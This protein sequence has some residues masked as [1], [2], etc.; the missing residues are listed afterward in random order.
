[1]RP[2]CVC[3]CVCVCVYIYI[4]KNLRG[5]PDIRIRIVDTQ[6][7]TVA[8]L[9]GRLPLSIIISSVTPRTHTGIQSTAFSQKEGLPV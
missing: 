5:D 6:L 2:Y 8:E 4:Y 9:N 3:V 1:M 7:Q